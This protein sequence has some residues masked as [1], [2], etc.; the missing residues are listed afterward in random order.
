L[1]GGFGVI[2]EIGSCDLAFEFGKPLMFPCVVKA[3]PATDW[4]GTSNPQDK[5]RNFQLRSFQ[6]LRTFNNPSAIRNQPKEFI[7][8]AEI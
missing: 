5:N 6:T 7:P 3:R 4:C 1:L 8:S 2:P